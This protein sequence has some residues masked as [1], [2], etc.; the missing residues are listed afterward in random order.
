[1]KLNQLNAQ[2]TAD[3][4]NEK[5]A[6]IFGEKVNLN[7]FTTEQ[8][9]VAREKVTAKLGSIQNEVSFDQLTNS[10]DYQKQR[11]LLDLLNKAI[12]ERHSNEGYHSKVEQD[13]EELIGDYFDHEQEKLK[14]SPDRVIA[15]IE[16]RK[17]DP[18]VIQAAIQKV[19]KEFEADGSM[20]DVTFEGNAFAQA[21][22]KAKA[23]GMK[24]G[25]KFKVGDETFTLEDCEKL[26]DE[27]KKKK[28]KSMS[29]KAKPDFLDIDKDGDTKEPM[30]KAIQDKEKDK[31]KKAVKEGAE[32]QAQLVMAAK[33][34]VDK[35]TGW[36]EDTANMMSE[37]LLELTD[38]IR[39][40][41]GT[42]QSE[43]YANQVK[44][45]LESLYSTLETTRESLTGGVAIVTGEQAPA[46]IGADPEVPAEEPTSDDDMPDQEDDFASSEPAT[47]G[48]EPAD[49]GK[50]ESILKLSRRLAE[51]LS[52]SEKK[53]A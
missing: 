10:E 36:M 43:A 14:M 44:P 30:K 23:A 8:L 27:M 11:M 42:D 53:K 5:F 12:E 39:D 24:K 20:K 35:I 25:D 50:R 13:A 40:E 41:L 46:K 31:K 3:T 28:M 16:S 19:K 45:A 4:V 38:A 7:S 6:K 52:R 18:A 22:Q 21:V 26:L 17:E 2:I 29:E 34:M 32:D 51:V 49:R 48:S 1:M 15:D 37:G 33:D 47:G 9:V